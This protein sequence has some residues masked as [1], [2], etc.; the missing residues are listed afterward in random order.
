MDKLRSVAT[1]EA[2]LLKDRHVD[3]TPVYPKDLL[4][5]QLANHYLNRYTTVN[6]LKAAVNW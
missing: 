4:A 1:R 5:D 6:D 2:L 3:E